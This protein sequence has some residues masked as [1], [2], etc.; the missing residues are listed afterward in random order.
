MNV[1]TYLLTYLL[2]LYVSESGHCIQYCRD[3]FL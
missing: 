3:R 2:M 1:F